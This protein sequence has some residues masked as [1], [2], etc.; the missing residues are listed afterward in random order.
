MNI[1][2]ARALL[3]TCEREELRDHAFGDA[4]VFWIKGKGEDRKE[5]AFGYFGGSSTG[6]TIKGEDDEVSFE[7]ADARALRECG[8]E[9]H[10]ERNDETG[11]DTFTEGDIMPGLSKGDVFHELTGSYLDES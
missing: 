1:D 5:V 8:T 9:G 7:G 6:I 2:E 11:P 3:D 10:V 4:E